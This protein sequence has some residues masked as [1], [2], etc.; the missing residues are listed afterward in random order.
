MTSAQPPGRSTDVTSQSST[1]RCRTRSLRR[2]SRSLLSITRNSVLV[3]VVRPAPSR[4]RSAAIRS[5]SPPSNDSPPTRFRPWLHVASSRSMSPSA[6]W[7][8]A[9]A[10]HCSTPV[11]VRYDDPGRMISSWQMRSNGS[12][13]VESSAVAYPMLTAVSSLSPVSTQILIIAF[14]SCAM[15]SPTRSWSLSSRAVTPCRR[16]MRCVGTD[17]S[18]SAVSRPSSV[19]ASSS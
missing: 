3:S 15:H 9:P 7:S 10:R 17:P 11:A 5:H 6:A 19:C 1:M 12:I 14:A 4:T 8:S 18:T 16:R 2:A 13:S